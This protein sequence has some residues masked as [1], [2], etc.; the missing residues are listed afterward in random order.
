MT[1]SA[2]QARAS[3]LRG[4]FMRFQARALRA[5]AMAI[6]LASDERAQAMYM[7]KAG[8]VLALGA[9]RSTPLHDDLVGGL[10][11]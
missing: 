2:W 5:L 4:R 9:S 1:P 3:E 8:A 11:Y 10:G 6:A 7:S